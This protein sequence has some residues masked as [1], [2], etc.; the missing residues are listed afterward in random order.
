M[1]ARCSG[2]PTGQARSS[3]LAPHVALAQSQRMP[4]RRVALS[5]H[6]VGAAEVDEA[7]PR[8]GG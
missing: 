2:A 4:Q 5:I 6:A 1:L 7:I 8:S 3:D